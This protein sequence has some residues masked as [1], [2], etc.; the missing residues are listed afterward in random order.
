MSYEGVL[1]KW[2]THPDMFYIGYGLL[3]EMSWPIHKIEC[4]C[5]CMIYLYHL[6][7]P[8]FI[9][10]YFS[11]SLCL[12]SVFSISFIY[13]T[14]PLPTHLSIR[15]SIYSSIFYLSFV[16]LSVCQHWSRSSEQ[17]AMWYMSGSCHS[18]FY[19]TILYYFYQ[20]PLWVFL[21]HINYQ[22]L[23]SK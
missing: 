13:L 12:S 23:L 14:I 10:I 1:K 9:F 3:P 21:S 11:H 17:P 16:S 2:I 6:F 19:L 8:P 18:I 7:P 20:F 15:L 5:L 4:A 22:E